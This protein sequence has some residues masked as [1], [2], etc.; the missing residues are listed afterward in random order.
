M[1]RPV[2]SV[3]LFWSSYIALFIFWVSCLVRV[4]LCR[5][6]RQREQRV[7]KSSMVLGASQL[8]CVHCVFCLG[9]VGQQAFSWLNRS[10]DLVR[11]TVGGG[12]GNLLRQRRYF[13]R[14]AAGAARSCAII[15]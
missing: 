1:A 12:R 15:T 9:G 5:T 14:V 13:L 11:G 10:S 8:G 3:L 4:R 2:A 6:L 7:F